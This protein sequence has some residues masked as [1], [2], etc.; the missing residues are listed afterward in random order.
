MSAFCR[1]RHGTLLSRDGRR[2]PLRRHLAGL[3]CS[4]ERRIRRDAAIQTGLGIFALQTLSSDGQSATTLSFGC[5]QILATPLH[6]RQTMTFS[7]ARSRAD[8]R[9][10]V[11]YRG[12]DRGCAA[13]LATS[14][15]SDSTRA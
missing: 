6:A 1:N 15:G 7:I 10:G 13:L 11:I 5:R 4:T 8:R 14:S 12:R 3:A 9:H 2:L